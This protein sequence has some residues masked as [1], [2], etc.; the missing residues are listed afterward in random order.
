MCMCMYPITCAV[1]VRNTPGREGPCLEEQ[2]LSYVYM[3]VH[4]PRRFT[5]APTG[6]RLRPGPGHRNDQRSTWQ[7]VARRAARCCYC[8]LAALVSCVRSLERRPARAAPP[9]P[10][11]AL[12]RLY[13]GV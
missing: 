7:W 5:G 11:Y 4:T 2:A 8:V 6:F 13:W 9:R 3:C 12:K 1:Y 10:A